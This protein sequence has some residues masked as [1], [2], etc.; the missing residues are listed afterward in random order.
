MTQGTWSYDEC[1]SPTAQILSE[2]KKE[3]ATKMTCRGDIRITIPA[4]TELVVRG[5]PLPRVTQGAYDVGRTYAHPLGTDG[6]MHTPAFRTKR[7]RKR[8]KKKQVGAWT[9]ASDGL[10]I[11][12]QLW[13]MGLCSRV[14]NGKVPAE[15]RVMEWAAV[16]VSRPSYGTTSCPVVL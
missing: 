8:K 11:C 1:S 12:S 13:E 7:S 4:E 16:T 6:P 2:K 15:N 3:E 10:G 14:R 5:R 9:P